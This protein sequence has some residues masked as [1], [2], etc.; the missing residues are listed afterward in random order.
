[1]VCGY[2]TIFGHDITVEMKPKVLL[3]QEKAKSNE[4]L[5]NILPYAAAQRLKSGDQVI[6]D[7]HPAVTV[8]FTDIVG[9]TPRSSGKAAEQVVAELLRLFTAFDGCAQPHRVTQKIKTIGDAYMCAM[10]WEEG[11]EA[12][13]AEML[14][15]AFE[16][17]EFSHGKGLDIREG[18]HIG[19]VVAGVV[20]VQKMTYDIWGT[21]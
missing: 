11:V 17:I 5:L 16:M 1:M 2:F 18:M 12:D 3:D 21:L 9:F 4:L 6:A 10:G 20:G 13:A 19:P 14:W 15:M 8:V 7:S